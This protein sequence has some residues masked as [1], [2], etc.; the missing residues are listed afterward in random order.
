MNKLLTHTVL[1][2]F[3]AGLFAQTSNDGMLY[4]SGGEELNLPQDPEESTDFTPLDPDDPMF[5]PNRPD[6]TFE[7]LKTRSLMIK[8]LIFIR[9]SKITK[10]EKNF[11]C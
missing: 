4:I 7:P 1:L 5:D 11:L 10:D 3:T 6:Y 9:E 2:F 8:I